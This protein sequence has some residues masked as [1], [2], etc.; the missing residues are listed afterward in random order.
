MKKLE[1]PI[2]V[3]FVADVLHG[4][5]FSGGVPKGLAGVE[6][7]LLKVMRLI[8][9]ER[10]RFSVATFAMEQ[11]LSAANQFP[12]PLYVFP[13]KKTYDWNA[14]KTAVKLRR[15]I[16]TQKVTI[17][18][19]FLESADIWGGLVAKLSGC[20]VLISSRRDMGCF[21]SA[22]HVL[23]YWL[24]NKLVDQVQAVSE[25]VRDFC[26]KSDGLSP[27]KVVTLYNG[28]EL[29]RFAAVNGLVDLRTELRLEPDAPVITTVANIRPVKGIDILIRA[30]AI[31]CSEFPRARFLIVGQVLDRPHFDQLRGL[32]ERLH[33][34][35]NII[36]LGKSEKVLPL[37]KLSTLFCLLSRSEGFSNAI[38]EAMATGLP[39]VVTAVGGNPEAIEDDRSGFLVESEDAETAA[40]R[41]LALLRHPERARR[42]GEV[43]RQTIAS[44]FTSEMMVDGWAKL[45]DDLLASRHA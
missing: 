2:H 9:R 32:V 10:Y 42:M 38:L 26:I 14:F 44:K 31:V 5:D 27:Q 15:L 16:R 6:G 11:T 43:G 41:I 40:D 17:V 4:L 45:Y 3:L 23:G 24:I 8:P 18:H 20:P 1:W 30:A 34:A 12:C 28:V 37:L 21:R 39:C 19:T 35:D 33:I 13:I 29:E 36:F 7:V 22:K 25:Q